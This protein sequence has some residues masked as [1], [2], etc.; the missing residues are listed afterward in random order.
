MD[1]S[2]EL[3]MTYKEAVVVN[4]KVPSRFLLE[5]NGHLVHGGKKKNAHRST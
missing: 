3:V 5:N 2:N 4:F 1:V